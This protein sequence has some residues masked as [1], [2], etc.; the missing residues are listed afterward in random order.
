[1]QLH[2]ANDIM[3]IRIAHAQVEGGGGKTPC[4]VRCMHGGSLSHAPITCDVSV[5]LPL[6]PSDI[7]Q[8]PIVRALQTLH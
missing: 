6:V 1:M 5:K 4:V 2:S 7:L 3:L 8:Q